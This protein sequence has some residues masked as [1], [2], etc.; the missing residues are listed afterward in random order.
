MSSPSTP[1]NR[2]AVVVQR[3]I[4]CQ[5]VAKRIDPL[6]QRWEYLA[7]WVGEAGDLHEVWYPETLI[8]LED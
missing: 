1:I 2:S 6:N 5:V 7:R 4:A 3:M 8:K